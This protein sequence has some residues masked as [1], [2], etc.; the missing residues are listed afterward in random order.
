MECSLKSFV[1][2]C[3][4]IC[5]VFL[6]LAEMSRRSANMCFIAA[7]LGDDLKGFCRFKPQQ[8]VECYLVIGAQ[9]LHLER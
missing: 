6:Y 9:T 1:E 8:R 7:F 2:R 3:K 5:S 4:L